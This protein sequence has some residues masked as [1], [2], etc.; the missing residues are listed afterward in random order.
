M[1][2]ELMISGEHLSLSLVKDLLA[3]GN[4]IHL[5]D[6]ARQNVSDCRN[7][8]DDKIADPNALYYGI[9]TGFGS[10]Y[11]VRIDQQQMEELQMNLIMSH[12]A[13]TG[14]TIP[15]E[16]SKIIVLL[17]ILS[18]TKGHSGVRLQLVDRLVHYFNHDM[19]PV[20]YKF[21]S[22]GASGDLAPLA[23]MS[24]TLL[25]KGSFYSDDGT[26]TSG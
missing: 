22:L 6:L 7:F 12:A 1:G 13:G 10:Q 16:V 25:G 17:K 5:D 21:G 14:D 8:L 18:L 15:R 9:S 4:S 20:M 19:I 26:C 11:H 24:L 2:G 3:E 23:H